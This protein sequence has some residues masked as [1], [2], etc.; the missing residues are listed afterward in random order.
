MQLKKFLIVETL[1]IDRPI[2]SDLSDDL[3]PK[4]GFHL[5]VTSANEMS[6]NFFINGNRLLASY[7]LLTFS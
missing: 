5:A 1:K 3:V 4:F 6:G 2:L 7:R